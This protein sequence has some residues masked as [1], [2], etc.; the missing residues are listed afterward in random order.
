MN[1]ASRLGEDFAESGEILLSASTRER[2]P[3]RLQTQ[4]VPRESTYGEH[5]VSYFVWR[6]SQ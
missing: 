3:E 5:S 4:A 1:S 2:L 6:P